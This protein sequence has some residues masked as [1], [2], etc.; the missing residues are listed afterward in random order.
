MRSGRIVVVGD[1]QTTFQ[2]FL[3]VLGARDLL[4]RAGRIREDVTLVTIGDYF[5]FARSDVD[6]AE[7]RRTGIEILAWLADHPPE[8][9]RILAGNHDLC[10]VMEFAGISD[11]DFSDAASLAQEGQTALLHERYP[12]IPSPG[13]ITRDFSAFCEAQK[14]QIQTLLM[15][16]RMRLA[17]VVVTADGREILITHAGVTKREAAILNA[18]GAVPRLLAAGLNEWLDRAV[19]RV[20]AD[21]RGGKTAAL[22]LAPLHIA[23]IAK[24]EGGGLLYHRPTTRGDSWGFETGCPRRF[25]PDS[26]PRGLHQVCGHTQHKKCLELMPDVVDEPPVIDGGL[27]SLVVNDTGIRYIGGIESPAPG[28]ACLWMVDSGLNRW[29]AD[30]VQVL[31]LAGAV[32]V[33]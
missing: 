17:E 15:T 31:Q 6:L 24:S 18:E 20:S 9:V 22:D 30:Q 33:P 8:Q 19:D 32:L 23:G 27:R 26:L 3:A 13:I 11:A 1:P 21:W 7:Y 29:S 4:T 14:K 10:R 28:D 25:L 16:R 2:Q 12:S 5:D